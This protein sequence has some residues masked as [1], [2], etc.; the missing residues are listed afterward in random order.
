M[1]EVKKG[2][3]YAPCCLHDLS[4]C[5]ENF[6]EDTF[7]GIRVWPTAK[8]ALEELIKKEDAESVEHWLR[9]IA[10]GHDTHFR[11]EP[12]KPKVPK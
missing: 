5:E 6:V 8:A 2:E 9:W 12:F 7:Q 10:T 1:A 4:Q 3:W 11:H